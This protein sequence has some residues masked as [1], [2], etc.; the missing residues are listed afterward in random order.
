M[1]SNWVLRR[2][3]RGLGEKFVEEEEETE[4]R[5]D[6]GEREGGGV[7]NEFEFERW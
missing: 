7:W 2:L 6:T 5:E 3:A 4:E 1:R